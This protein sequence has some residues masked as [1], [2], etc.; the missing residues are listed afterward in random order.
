M[1]SGRYIWT[2]KEMHE[3]YGPIVRVMPDA[4]HV[5][6]PAFV[7]QLYPGQAADKRRDRAW[8]VSNKFLDENSVIATRDHDLHRKRRAVLSPFFSRQN[9]RLLVPTINKVLYHFLDRLDQ[10]PEESIAKLNPLCRAA[11]TDV[12]QAYVFGESRMNILMDDYNADFFQTLAPREFTH[13]SAYFPWVSR[14]LRVM[15]VSMVLSLNPSARAFVDFIEVR[16]LLSCKFTVVFPF[17]S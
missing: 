8:T 14:I 13:V 15:P 12:I 7:D 2:I 17:P 6:D 4:V 10:V 3:R 1:R 5:N 11:T 16:V 9:V